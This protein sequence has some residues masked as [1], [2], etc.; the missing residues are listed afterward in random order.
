MIP[1]FIVTGPAVKALQAAAGKGKGASM[2]PKGLD[3]SMAKMGK[4]G[5]MFGKFGKEDTV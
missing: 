4:L 3:K 5:K 1:L 2:L